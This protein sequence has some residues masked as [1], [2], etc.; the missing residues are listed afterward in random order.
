MNLAFYQSFYP[1]RR[2]RD[3]KAGE[4]TALVER[5]YDRCSNRIGVFC[6]GVIIGVFLAIIGLIA[7]LA[8]SN[9][10]VAR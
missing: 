8:I 5:E 6:A 3:E 10:D 9:K 1:S 7:F 4:T 2:S